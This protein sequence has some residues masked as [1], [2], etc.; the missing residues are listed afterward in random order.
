MTFK[1]LTVSTFATSLGFAA[2]PCISSIF[3]Q[4]FASSGRGGHAKLLQIYSNAK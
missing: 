2:A 1:P 3:I 4:P